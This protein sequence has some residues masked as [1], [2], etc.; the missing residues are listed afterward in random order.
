MVSIQ[1]WDSGIGIPAGRIREIFEEFQQVRAIAC[2]SDKGQ[3]LGLPVVER[4]ARAAGH[5]LGVRS[6]VGRG[7][8]FE[9][10]VPLA[11]G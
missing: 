1:V 3:G 2:E 11:S 10:V 8:V 7:S 6:V 4:L 9:L 5:P